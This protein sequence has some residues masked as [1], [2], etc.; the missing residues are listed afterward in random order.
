[1]KKGKNRYKSCSDLPFRYNGYWK[2]PFLFYSGVSFESPYLLYNKD[3]LNHIKHVYLN[4]D[5]ECDCL[6]EHYFICNTN[7][8]NCYTEINGVYDCDC[9]RCILNTDNIFKIGLYPLL[10]LI[11]MLYRKSM[12][13][14]QLSTEKQEEDD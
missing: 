3:V 8:I 7:S 11:H 9:E 4:N 2:V 14:T 13:S 5:L 1:M 12:Y 6:I 10:R